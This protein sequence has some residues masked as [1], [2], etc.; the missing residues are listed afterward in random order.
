MTITKKE[1]DSYDEIKGML[2][3]IRRIQAQPKYGV[4]QEQ[5]Y[6]GETKEPQ[7]SRGPLT[8]PYGYGAGTKKPIPR[9]VGTEPEKSPTT[10]YQQSRRDTTPYQQSRRDNEEVSVIN[11]VDVEIHSEDPQDRELQDDEKGT[12]SQLI[13]DFKGEVSEIAE[14]DGLHIYPDSAVL[15]GKIGGKGMNFSYS[16]GDD[17]GF[18][19]GSPSLLKIDSETLELINRLKTFEPKFVNTINDLLVNRRDM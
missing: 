6:Q 18:Y 2:N 19:L 9:S 13:D 5:T 7:D 10:P 11:N 4:I 15:N 17:N 8:A 16:A 12:I 3:K 1:I 14:F